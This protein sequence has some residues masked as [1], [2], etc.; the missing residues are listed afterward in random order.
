MRSVAVCAAVCSLCL[1]SGIRAEDISSFSRFGEAVKTDYAD[2]YSLGRLEK[3]AAGLAVGGL[4]ANTSVDDDIHEWYTNEVRSAHTDDLS[5]IVKPLGN[6]WIGIPVYAGASLLRLYGENNSTCGVI[7]EWGERSL[8]TVMV[9]APAV[10][11]LQW[12]L[13]GARPEEGASTW[14]PFQDSN[15][16]SGHSFMGAVPLM[17][18]A[19]M[20]DNRILKS[21]FYFGSTLC[22]LSRVN[23]DDHYFSQSLLG[24]WLAYLSASSVDGTERENRDLTL[25]PVLINGHAGIA[26]TLAF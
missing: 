9:G 18:A 17:S 4:V 2:F 16:V 23:D 21:A 1:V 14:R 20:T 10:G 8:R 6:H 22:G 12:I 19:K 24:W 7:G 3:L 5:E 25:A 26:V 15:G 13:G 11:A